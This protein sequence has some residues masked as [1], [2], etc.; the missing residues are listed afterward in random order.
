MPLEGNR[1]SHITCWLADNLV[2]DC[3]GCHKMS[4]IR[5]AGVKAVLAS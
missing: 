4:G 2:L 1:E 3:R 5:K